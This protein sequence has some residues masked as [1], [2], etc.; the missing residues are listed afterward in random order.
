MESFTRLITP[1][2]AENSIARTPTKATK[3]SAACAAPAG[4]TF[5]TVSTAQAAVIAPSTKD[6]D[7]AACKAEFVSVNVAS[8]PIITAIPATTAVNTINDL[9]AP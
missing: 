2:S 3:P 1:P 7:S 8:K 9:V 4:L 6:I 5:A